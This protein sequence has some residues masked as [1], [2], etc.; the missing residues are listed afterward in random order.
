MTIVPNPG[1]QVRNIVG[2]LGMLAGNANLGR[3]TDFTDMFKIF[4]SSLDTLNEAGLEQLAKK[5]SLTGV[6]DTSL[7][8]RALEEYRNAGRDLTVSGK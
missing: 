7:V 1:A 8:T 6:A 3:D 4:T 2:N 5:I